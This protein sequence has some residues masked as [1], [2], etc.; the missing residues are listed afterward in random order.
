MWGLL[1]LALLRQLYKF[2][3]RI[4]SHPPGLSIRQTKCF[5]AR[6]KDTNE[7]LL[8]I[9]DTNVANVSNDPLQELGLAIPGN[10]GRLSLFLLTLTKWLINIIN[11][12]M[13]GYYF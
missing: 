13:L 11:N 5:V 7:L 2:I 4:S 1:Q 6:N 10:I 3:T 12:Y 9:V 8:D